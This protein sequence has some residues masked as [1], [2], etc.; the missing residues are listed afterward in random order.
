MLAFVKLIVIIE[1]KGVKEA[2]QNCS[3]QAEKVKAYNKG[4]IYG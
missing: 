2:A 1:V 4:G 3:G